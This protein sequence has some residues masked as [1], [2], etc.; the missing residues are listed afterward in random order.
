VLKKMSLP[1]AQDFG[2][3]MSNVETETVPIHVGEA[4]AFDLSREL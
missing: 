1:P 2:L 3:D 4:K